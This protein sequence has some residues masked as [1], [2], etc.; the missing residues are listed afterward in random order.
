MAKIDRALITLALAWLIL[1]MLLGFYMGAA[2][3]T[4]LLDVHV[5]ML[6][7]GFVLL[8]VYGFIYRLWPLLKQ[9][10]LAKAQFWIAAL[11]SVG[12]IVGAAQMVLGWGIITVAAGSAVAI[13]GAILMGWLFVTAPEE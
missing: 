2:A 8:S 12:T 4:S 6:L 1:G 3:D 9:S 11:G 13:I 7:G 5:A 10:R